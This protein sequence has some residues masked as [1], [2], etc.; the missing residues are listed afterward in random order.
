MNVNARRAITNRTTTNNKNATFA[1]K[2]LDS[3]NSFDPKFAEGPDVPDILPNP[4][5]FISIY[6]INR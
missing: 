6:N 1:T 2:L 4:K 3:M 5:L